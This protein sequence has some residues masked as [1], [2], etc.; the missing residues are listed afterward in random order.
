MYQVTVSCR[1]QSYN[2]YRLYIIAQ[3]TDVKNYPSIMFT[4]HY[5]PYCNIRGSQKKKL[6]F[7]TNLKNSEKELDK[8]GEQRTAHK[9]FH[10]DTASF[11][12][13][14]N[15][16]MKCVFRVSGAWLRLQVSPTRSAAALLFLRVHAPPHTQEAKHTPSG[17]N[18]P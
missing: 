8:R 15:H 7:R 13:P 18:S 17:R 10:A 4:K 16:L 14:G 11:T 1:I 12:R 6:Y 9:K 2:F 3:K 5:S